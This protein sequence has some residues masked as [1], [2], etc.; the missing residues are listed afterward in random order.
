MDCFAGCNN[1][2]DEVA[3]QAEFPRRESAA[4]LGHLVDAP[5]F[6]TTGVDASGGNAVDEDGVETLRQLLLSDSECKANSVP[7]LEGL[8]AFS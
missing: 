1:S 5:G 7:K 3:L 4:G 2:E 6:P 8:R